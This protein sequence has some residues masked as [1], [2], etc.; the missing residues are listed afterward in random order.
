MSPDPIPYVI[1]NRSIAPPTFWPST[2][3]LGPDGNEL[4]PP[5]CEPAEQATRVADARKFRNFPDAFAFL[6]SAKI[7]KRG[8]GGSF[9]IVLAD[10][11]V[12]AS[13]EAMHRGR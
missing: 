1:V 10:S 7:L 8:V 3:I 2:W 6:D 4:V 5:R 13:I 12:V 11:P 9:D